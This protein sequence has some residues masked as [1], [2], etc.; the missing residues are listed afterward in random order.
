MCPSHLRL[1]PALPRPRGHSRKPTPTH[2]KPCWFSLFILCVCMYRLQGT[3]GGP[4]TSCHLSRIPVHAVRSSF[5]L[6]PPRARLPSPISPPLM[7]TTL[8]PAALS[9]PSPHALTAPGPCSLC[10]C[11]ESRTGLLPPSLR[12]P[13]FL[14]RTLSASQAFKEGGGLQPS[15]GWCLTP[16]GM[17]DAPTPPACALSGEGCALSLPS[18]PR[19]WPCQVARQ[20]RP[21]K[22]KQDLFSLHCPENKGQEMHLLGPLLGLSERPCL[23]SSW[24]PRQEPATFP[25]WP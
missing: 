20:P 6:C 11:Q 10:V 17:W 7:F 2:L 24:A 5:L 19:P 15:W 14:S 21:L 18:F 4:V 1:H 12:H 23:G 22:V 16:C 8:P 3:H 13:S 25:P 9:F